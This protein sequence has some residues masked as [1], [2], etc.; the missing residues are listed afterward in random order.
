MKANLRHFISVSCFHGRF[1]YFFSSILKWLL[2]QHQ[3]IF[4]AYLMLH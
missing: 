2:F 4:Q 1:S 3:P